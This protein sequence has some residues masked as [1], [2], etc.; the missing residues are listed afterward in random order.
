MQIAL[1][2]FTDDS[3]H[4]CH[5]FCHLNALEVAVMMNVKMS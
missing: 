5:T 4:K 3:V 2:I 1:G